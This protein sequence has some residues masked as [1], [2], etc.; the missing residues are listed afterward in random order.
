MRKISLVLAVLIIIVSTFGLS[1]CANYDFAETGTVII[2]A[3]EAI[4]LI[5][6]DNTVLVDLRSPADYEKQHV[7]NA[8]NVPRNAINVDDPF[9]NMLAPKEQIEEVMGQNGISNDTLVIAYDS[10]N[11]MDASRLWWTLMAY[12]HEN[13]KVVSGGFKALAEANAGLSDIPPVVQPVVFVTKE[14]NEA[15]IAY[16]SDVLN[17]VNDPDE[18]VVLIDTRSI[19]EHNM[20]TIPSSL[21]IDYLTNNYSDG[22]FRSIQDIQIMYLEKDIKPE[23]TVII[24]CLTSIRGAQTYAAMWNAGYRNLKLYDGAWT[25]WIADESVPADMPGE[26]QAP[27]NPS[28]SDNS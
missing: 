19:Q 28:Q 10:S 6:N 1:G 23:T 7:Q 13:V 4:A 14:L 20:G 5:G 2:T 3:K 21:N 18:N 16:K 27:V 11:N 8:V 15:F 25:E 9:S 12:G 24:Y 26:T 17:Q 22:T